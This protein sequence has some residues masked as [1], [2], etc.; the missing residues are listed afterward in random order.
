MN[1]A[2]TTSIVTIVLSRTVSE[3]SAI[4]VENRQFFQPPCIKRPQW[5]GSPWNLVSVQGVPNASMMG[6]PDGRKKFKIGLRCLSVQKDN[7]QVHLHSIFAPPHEYLSLKSFSIDASRL[8]INAQSDIMSCVQRESGLVSWFWTFCLQRSVVSRRNACPTRRRRLWLSSACID[9]TLITCRTRA[10][11]V[12]IWRLGYDAL[13]QS[14][15][16]TFEIGCVRCCSWPCLS[17]VAHH[18]VD[19]CTCTVYLLLHTSIYRGWVT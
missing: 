6:L 4:S 12:F 16:D 11:D 13:K 2:P 18:W 5:R 10:C 9:G 7:G 15:M 19:K 14:N 17:T 8:K 3:I 1:P